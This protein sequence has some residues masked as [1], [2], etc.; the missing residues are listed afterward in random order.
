MPDSYSY[1]ALAKMIDHS[2]L[3]PAPDGGR[4]GG[5]LPARPALRRSQRMHTAVLKL[6]DFSQPTPYDV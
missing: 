3:N 1:E 6:S 5:G 4:T 2:L